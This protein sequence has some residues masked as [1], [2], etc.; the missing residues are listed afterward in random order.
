MD[1]EAPKRKSPEG[2]NGARVMSTETVSK[3]SI[4]TGGLDAVS[5]ASR[6]RRSR[7]KIKGLKERDKKTRM[8][9]SWT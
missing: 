5:E 4:S 3:R 7:S 2:A 9:Y 6:N 8:K 1:R